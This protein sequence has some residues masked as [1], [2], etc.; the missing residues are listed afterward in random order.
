MNNKKNNNILFRVFS[1]LRGPCF[2]VFFVVL[3][4]VGCTKSPTNSDNTN[5]VTVNIAITQNTTW[6]TG[7]DYIIE[8]LVTVQQGVSL[9]ITGNVT[10]LFKA[11]GEGEKG[12]LRINGTLQA[13]GTDSTSAVLFKPYDATVSG[14]AWGIELDQSEGCGIFEFCRFEGLTYGVNAFEAS[15]QVN[16]CIF[17]ECINGVSVTKCDSALIQGS[18]FLDNEYG[19]KTNLAPVGEDSVRV[20]GNVFSGAKE[21]GV[22]V[23]NFS[24]GLIK[25]N[26]FKNNFIG[27]ELFS[28]S[29]FSIIFNLFKYNKTCINVTSGVKG[30]IIKN[31]FNNSGEFIFLNRYAQVKINFNNFFEVESYKIRLG[32]RSPNVNA[33]ENWWNNIKKEVIHTFIFDNNDEGAPIDC[34]IVFFEPFANTEIEW[35]CQSKKE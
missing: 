17:F 19:I 20:I 9:T 29:S 22:E 28:G 14:G 32:H 8:G 1:V 24:K 12:K 23:G 21:V 27:V 13:K 18:E 3:L 6:Q 15:V 31:N 26:F 35:F 16:E 11:D 33:I 30:K 10:I 5:Q 34:G 7:T 4:F 2:F 25:G